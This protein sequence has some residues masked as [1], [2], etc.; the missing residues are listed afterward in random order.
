MISVLHVVH[1]LGGGSRATAGAEDSDASAA[2]AIKSPGHAE[3]SK[4]TWGAYDEA[5]P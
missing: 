5:S 3:V 1:R 4:S 2:R